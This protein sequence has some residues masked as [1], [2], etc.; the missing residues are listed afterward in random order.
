MHET[1]SKYNKLVCD[2]VSFSLVLQVLLHQIHK[3]KANQQS[4]GITQPSCKTT[5]EISQ[6]NS[7][8]ASG[9]S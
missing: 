9:L 7:V 6:L 8:G 4:V 5:D 1:H 2:M 3:D